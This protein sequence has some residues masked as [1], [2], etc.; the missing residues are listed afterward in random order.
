MGNTDGQLN[1]RIAYNSLTS[2]QA[3]MVWS[4]P[5]QAVD[6]FTL[7]WGGQPAVQVANNRYYY[8]LTKLTATTKYTV[9]LTAYLQNGRQL[10]ATQEFT[11]LAKGKVLDVSQA[12]YNLSSGQ[13]V[14]TAN[15]QRAIDD[16][17][18]GGTVLIPQG[19]S[20]VSGALDLH[21]HMTLQVDG[22]LIASTDPFDYIR[23]PQKDRSEGID[24]DDLIWTRYEGWEMK[25]FR[26]LINVG[27]L[28]R[29]QRSTMTCRDVRICGQGI[30]RGSGSQLGD[31]MESYFTDTKRY[32]QYIS[33]NI[34]GRRV[35]GRLINVIQTDGIDLQDVQLQNPPCWTLH[36]IYSQHI[37]VDSVHINSVG[38]DNGD[39]IDPDSCS[40]VLIFGATFDTGD[41][42]I[43]IK[44][45]KNPEGNQVAIPTSD[46]EIF[47]L[48]MLGGHG[49]AIGTEESAGV[50]HVIVHDCL[51]HDT[52]FGIEL[53]ASNERGGGVDDFTVDHCQIDSFFAHSVNYNAD[54]QAAN[55]LP[56]FKRLKL[57]NSRI[58][59][60][61][62]QEDVMGN[63]IDA[64]GKAI[65]VIGFK[66]HDVAS[67][68]T[69][70]LIQNVSLAHGS[71]LCSLDRCADVCL[72]HVTVEHGQLNLQVG[73]DTQHFRIN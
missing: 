38:I 68:I 22:Q 41:D 6:H 62:H 49:M 4:R 24:L 69:D 9:T 70:L 30:I 66:D 44:S 47:N 43:A 27:H 2:Q 11:T 8:E 57:T 46:V 17:S 34:P 18:D 54:G 26:S 65:E 40:H 29:E 48:Q 10:Q 35:R 33:D 23:N 72:D 20:I 45:G 67:P 56:V 36:L 14:Q 3:T 15:L 7:Q 52:N 63:P 1:L 13:T 61:T 51:I 58:T 42:C 73:P 53:K 19:L 25:C 16:C 21:S 31:A 71:S 50:S 5:A 60:N 28:D 64:F 32:P 55:E 39:G 59:G 12:P 37:T